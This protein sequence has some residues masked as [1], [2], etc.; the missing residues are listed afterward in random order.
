MIHGRI[1]SENN[2]AH[3]ENIIST[4]INNDAMSIRRPKAC[5]EIY[6]KLNLLYRQFGMCSPD[7]L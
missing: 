3:V 4:D 5:N 1:A 2:E 6:A 7:V